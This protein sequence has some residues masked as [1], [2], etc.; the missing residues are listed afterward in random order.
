MGGSITHLCLFCDFYFVPFFSVY[1]FMYLCL[2]SKVKMVLI[3]QKSDQKNAVTVANH[4]DQAITSQFISGLTQ[5]Y[6]T[7]LA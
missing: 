1:L 5:V 7:H 6:S 3:D 2:F 4:S